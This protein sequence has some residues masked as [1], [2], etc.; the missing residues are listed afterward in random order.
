MINRDRS[1]G[2][3]LNSLNHNWWGDRPN[4]SEET[5]S[6]NIHRDWSKNIQAQFEQLRH[7]FRFVSCAI[8]KTLVKLE[9]PIRYIQVGGYLNIK[10]EEKRE[11]KWCLGLGIDDQHRFWMKTFEQ[12]SANSL[13]CRKKNWGAGFLLLMIHILCFC[14]WKNPA[15][16][17]YLQST[18]N[19][20][21]IS[22]V[23]SQSD[24]LTLLCSLF[25]YKMTRKN[26]WKYCFSLLVN[27]LP[28]NAKSKELA[29]SRISFI[30]N[31]K[32]RA[33]AVNE[34][35]FNLQNRAYWSKIIMLH[36]RTLG[37][38]LS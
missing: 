22:S 10:E 18:E 35:S 21:C 29:L 6:V 8:K 17:N 36:S 25:R 7:T 33:P 9:H 31:H 2:T 38:L 14:R 24:S 23:D 27:V 16:V 26:I 5:K 4:D 13:E 30:L 3:L 15:K 1:E 32:R 20:V 34:N 11:R 37:T 28:L 19:F 12:I